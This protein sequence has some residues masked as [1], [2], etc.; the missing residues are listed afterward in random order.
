MINLS[1]LLS[2][3][4]WVMLMLTGQIFHFRK[5][6]G[7]MFSNHVHTNVLKEKKVKSLFLIKHLTIEKHDTP[8]SFFLKKKKEEVNLTICKKN[9]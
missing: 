2:V 5:A 8:Y 4:I 7:W 9:K 3:T 6:E 1:N